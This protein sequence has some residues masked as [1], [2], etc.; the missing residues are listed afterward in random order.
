MNILDDTVTTFFSSSNKHQLKAKRVLAHFPKR[1]E[2]YNIQNTSVM[3]DVFPPVSVALCPSALCPRDCIFCSNSKR[4]AKS[5][6][7]VYEYSESIIDP[8]IEDLNNFGVKG[9][10]LAGGGEPLVYNKGNLFLK[11]TKENNTFSLGFHTNG[12]F[13]DKL[14]LPQITK[15]GKIS[16]INISTVAHKA[17]LYSRITRAG[18]K[19]FYKIEENLKAAVQ[20]YSDSSSSGELGVKIIICRENYSYVAHMVEYFKK[21][22]LENI[23][24]RCVGNFEPEQDVELLPSQ[25]DSFSSILKNDLKMTDSQIQAVTG[26]SPTSSPQIPSR[27]W[28]IGSGLNAGIYPDGNV[29]VCTLWSQ[30][31]HSIG[32]LNEKRFRDIWGSDKHKEIVQKLNE[33][34]LTGQCDPLR[35]RLYYSNLLVDQYFEQLRNADS[36]HIFGGSYENFI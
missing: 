24:I 2:N 36:H 19:Q 3:Q 12:V 11:L 23:L 13:L 33:K 18:E 35:C 7:T 20:A 1:L 22:G 5:R 30:K 9:V 16:Y 25:Y 14:L 26:K 10:T 4:N 34:L 6:E 17:E 8:L 28:M 29:C 15:S 31:E 21:L 27:C 32:N